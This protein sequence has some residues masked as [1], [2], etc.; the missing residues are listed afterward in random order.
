MAATALASL[1]APN[2]WM[3]KVRRHRSVLG[4]GLESEKRS[5]ESAGDEVVRGRAV[6][7]A[8][9]DGFAAKPSKMWVQ[10]VIEEQAPRADLM[11]TACIIAHD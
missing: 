5:V 9:S 3:R 8:G 4:R 1:S 10:V 6:G 11:L 2:R 7:L